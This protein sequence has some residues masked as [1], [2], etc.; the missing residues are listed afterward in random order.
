[1]YTILDLVFCHPDNFVKYSTIAI[2]YGISTLQL[3]YK[4]SIDIRTYTIRSGSDG[5]SRVNAVC[6]FVL[7]WRVCNTETSFNVRRL[8]YVTSSRCLW[9]RAGSKMA[10]RSHFTV[11]TQKKLSEADATKS[12]TPLFWD[13]EVSSDDAVAK[14]RKLILRAFPKTI[15]LF[16]R[17]LS[18]LRIKLESIAVDTSLRAVLV[19]SFGSVGVGHQN[20]RKYGSYVR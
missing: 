10:S 11:A 18:P 12:D 1:M 14:F 8:N 16:F 4:C 20:G 3:H 9:S 19:W 5:Y 17:N 13:D 7:R 6:G 2:K 15:S